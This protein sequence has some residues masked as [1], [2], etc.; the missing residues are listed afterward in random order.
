MQRSESVDA[1]SPEKKKRDSANRELAR[2]GSLVFYETMRMGVLKSADS[3]EVMKKAGPGGPPPQQQQQQAQQQPQQPQDKVSQLEKKVAELEARLVRKKKKVGKKR[4]I[5]RQ[6]RGTIAQLVE[7]VG[8]K[9]KMLKKLLEQKGLSGDNISPRS[10]APESL[11]PSPPKAKREDETNKEKEKEKEKE[12]ENEKEKEKKKGKKQEEEKEKGKKQE[13]EK[14]KT[15][16]GETA[17][18]E[19]EEQPE[20][21]FH[22]SGQF[23][24]MNTTLKKSLMVAEHHHVHADPAPTTTATTSMSKKEQAAYVKKEFIQTEELYVALL[25]ILIQVSRVEFPSLLY[26]SLLLYYLNKAYVLPLKE[27]ASANDETLV[28]MYFHPLPS[29]ASFDISTK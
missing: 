15:K 5:M 19:E 27:A 7:D 4:K 28:T 1:R 12:N 23:K 22:I 29:L 21:K 18:T 25:E 13:E 6:Q 20:K 14:K 24:L 16:E 26:P 8:N 11:A 10:N 9:D 2:S 3:Y 17:T